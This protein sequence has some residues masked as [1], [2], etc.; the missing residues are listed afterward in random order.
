MSGGTCHVSGI[1]RAYEPQVVT[2]AF[3]TGETF[4]TLCNK[5]TVL[6]TLVAAFPVGR[7]T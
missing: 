6:W 2:R 5:R 1:Y 7:E 3:Y 4:T